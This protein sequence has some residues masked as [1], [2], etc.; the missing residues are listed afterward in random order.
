MRFGTSAA[1][2]AGFVVALGANIATSQGF[3]PFSSSHGSVDAVTLQIFLA[4]ALI[5]SFVVAAM[6]SDLADRNE[7]HR[8]LTHQATHDELTGLPNR[9]L[10]DQTLDEAMQMRQR[11]GGAVGVL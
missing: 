1:A 11:T 10:F 5:S 7:V 6:A 2:T 3:G 4:I 8:L 9:A